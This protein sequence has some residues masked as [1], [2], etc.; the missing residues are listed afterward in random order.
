MAATCARR[1]D[2]CSGRLIVDPVEQVLGDLDREI[3][4]LREGAERACHSAAAGVEHCGFS[5]RQS[6][7]ESS[8]ERRIH[9]RFGVAM[10]VD[11]DPATAGLIFEAKRI[12]FLREQII[13]KFFEQKTTL[14][15]VVG[16]LN[17]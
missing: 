10:G 13:D 17:L 12:R 7:R 5:A 14:R 15:D 4:F 11:R 9:D 2:L 6:L 1:N 16:V 8:Q 3:I